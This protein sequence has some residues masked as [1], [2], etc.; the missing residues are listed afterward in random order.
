M[1]PVL[2]L[3]PALGFAD[4]LFLLLVV[5][6]SF[7][8]FDDNVVVDDDV[9]DCGWLVELVVVEVFDA[10]CC[11]TVVVLVVSLVD[12]DFPVPPLELCLPDD[13]TNGTDAGNDD[14]GDWLV[15]DAN[16][17]D[18]DDISCLL[19]EDVNEFCLLV[20]CW[21][22]DE[23]MLFVA[24]ENCVDDKDLLVV[25]SVEKRG[26]G[27]VKE[28]VLLIKS[29]VLPSSL[30]YSLVVA[31]VEEVVLIANDCELSRDFLFSSHFS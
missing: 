25:E 27:N 15:D 12:D 19:D 26:D 5:L 17:D 20:G 29:V 11:L 8:S 13:G 22:D 10:C 1:L 9:N 18:D 3:V 31:I 6:P 4:L 24:D 28:D 30:L 14:D 23:L 21:A 2:P 7:L 16:L